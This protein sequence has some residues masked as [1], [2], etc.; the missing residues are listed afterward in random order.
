MAPPTPFPRPPVD[1]PHSRAVETGVADGARRGALVVDFE[2][3]R[4]CRRAAPQWRRVPAVD[5]ERPTAA[6]RG[7]SARGQEEGRRDGF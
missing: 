1:G 5:A 4:A 3:L 6:G 2:L 7:G